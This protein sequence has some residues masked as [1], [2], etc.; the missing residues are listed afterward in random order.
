MPDVVSSAASKRPMDAA[1]GANDKSPNGGDAMDIDGNIEI[2]AEKS[3]ILK[4]HDSEVFICAWNPKQD[5]LA[6]GSGDSTARIWNLTQ[7]ES[8]SSSSNSS[9][10][11]L[12]HCTKNKEGKEVPSNK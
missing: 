12:Q 3:T 10:K 9:V 4:G 6:S 8:S 2:P 7:A 11:V 5:L 1:G